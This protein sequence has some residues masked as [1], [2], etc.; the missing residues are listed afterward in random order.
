MASSPSTSTFNTELARKINEQ[1]RV[2]P[3][4]PY[5]GKFV[6]ILSGQVVAVAD[7][8]DRL[9]HRLQQVGADLGQT[10]CLEVGLDYD[11]AQEIWGMF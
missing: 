2:D 1:A 10:L 5:A 11:R 3:G 8:L 7:D 4:S 9:I 6:G